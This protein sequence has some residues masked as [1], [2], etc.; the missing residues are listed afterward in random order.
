MKTY[1]GSERAGRVRKPIHDMV[2]ESFKVEAVQGGK[3]DG[4]SKTPATFCLE[5]SPELGRA[6][7]K[8]CLKPGVWT[9]QAGI[10]M[11]TAKRRVSLVE[12]EED[13]IPAKTREQ[14]F[15][16]QPGWRV[17]VAD[18]YVQHEQSHVDEPDV[19]SAKVAGFKK[20]IVDGP[21][22]AFI[23]GCAVAEAGRIPET[24]AVTELVVLNAL[25]A[26]TSAVPA[27][28][29]VPAEERIQGG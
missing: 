26:A 5:A 19:A 2:H 18:A 17:D 6:F 21:R 3:A 25:R 7:F 24:Q 13:A 22:E 12:S 28:G 10:P 9:L 27:F 23:L 15:L 16:E 4:L 29:N 1:S 8:F 11:A 20:E 14:N